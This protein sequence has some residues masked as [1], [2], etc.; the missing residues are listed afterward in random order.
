MLPNLAEKIA[1]HEPK[2]GIV[3][4]LMTRYLPR[5]SQQCSQRTSCFWMNFSGRELE[6]PRRALS[7]RNRFSCTARQAWLFR[8]FPCRKSK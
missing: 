2:F 5:G 7:C 8:S 1:D 4:P 3:F 6:K